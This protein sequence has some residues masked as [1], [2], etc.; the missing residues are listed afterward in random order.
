MARAAVM[1]LRAPHQDSPKAVCVMN[2]S[3]PPHRIRIRNPSFSNARHSKRTQR[4]HIRYLNLVLQLTLTLQYQISTN[5]C[6]LCLESNGSRTKSKSKPHYHPIGN[7][8]VFIQNLANFVITSP[9]RPSC[10]FFLLLLDRPFLAVS[11]PINRDR[12]QITKSGK[13]KP[14]NE[15]LERIAFIVL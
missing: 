14:S 15:G 7:R 12:C 3:K 13:R 4:R 1:W 9:E 11:D 8:C 10:L 2:P 5:P 6:L